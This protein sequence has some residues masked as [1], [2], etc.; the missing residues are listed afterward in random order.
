MWA[1]KYMARYSGPALVVLLLIILLVLIRYDSGLE[2]LDT[3][4]AA[5]VAPAMGN[6]SIAPKQSFVFNAWPPPGYYAA[7][8]AGPTRSIVS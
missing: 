4:D 6:A 1:P 5:L 3:A 7:L 8:N 2:H